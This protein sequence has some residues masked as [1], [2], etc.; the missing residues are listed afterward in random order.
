MEPDNHAALPPGT[1]IG[2][3]RFDGVLGQGGF[4]ITYLGED[5]ALRRAVAIKEYLPAELA[6]RV[7][8]TT[9]KPLTGARVD[10]FGWGLNRFLDEA[11]TLA[12]FHHPN[13]VAVHDVFEQ[14]GTAYMVMQHEAGEGL[15]AALKARRYR[16]EAELRALLAP[17]LEGLEKVHAA[18][19]VHRDIKPANIIIRTDGTPVLIDFG[20]AREAV[21][22][23]TRTLTAMVSE[24]YAPFEQ[25]N[26]T[27]DNN[28]QG[29]WTDIYSLGAMLYRAVT[30]RAPAGALVRA[31]TLLDGNPDPVVPA[32]QAAAGSYS[33][34][35][36]RAIDAA[37]AFRAEDRPQSVAAWRE[38]LAAADDEP[39][40]ATV[41]RRAPPAP[42]RAPAGPT[43]PAHPAGAPPAPSGRRGRVP[44]ALAAAVVVAIAVAAGAWWWSDRDTAPPVAPAG[45][46]AGSSGDRAAVQAAQAEQAA[47][48]EAAGQQAAEKAARLEE[49]RRRRVEAEQAA[50]QEE[51][52]RREI[53]AE[54]ATQEA[55][56]REARIAALLEQAGS[57]IAA[58]R[59][60]PPD[61]DSAASLFAEVLALEPDS[62]EAR[63]G[64]GQVAGRL[65]ADAEASMGARRLDEAAAIIDRADAV[66]PG[67]A[68]VGDARR[69]L[70]AA[71]EALAV[72]QAKAR[73]AASEQQPSQVEA[74]ARESEVERLLAQ[75]EDAIASLRLTSP[76]GDNAVEYLRRVQAME[77]GN[78][79]ASAGLGRV[80]SR[81]V[82][83]ADGA[84]A[85]GDA[86][87]AE[88][89]LER[90][91]SVEAGTEVV[92][93]ARQR[94]AEAGDASRAAAPARS[95]TPAPA[96]APAVT[97]VAEPVPAAPAAARPGLLVGQVLPGRLGS[98]YQ[99][100]EAQLTE[101]LEGLDHA[102][103]GFE[104]RGSY[105]RRGDPA[106][107][108]L[109]ADGLYDAPAVAS[110]VW[111]N[112]TPDV[113]GARQVAASLGADAV[114][115]G[116]WSGNAARRTYE[117][118]FF[119]IDAASGE[120]T[121]R[122]GD[123]VDAERVL[124]ELLAG[125]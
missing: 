66:M 113:A 67:S 51:A 107:R 43:A 37:L 39:H 112:A 17:L 69:R 45:D 1:V 8:G 82:E 92:A 28:R 10:T 47:R 20:S 108:D 80:V 110:L 102:A 86:A 49:E 117:V 33:L 103:A 105:Y 56:E 40:G 36:L 4:G 34:G 70:A 50:R 116:V 121:E 15:D 74:R 31:H 61:A 2:K 18:G 3:Y 97:A 119:L 91:D 65:L 122:V 53:E 44:V 76:A 88:A 114:L 125:R 120:V 104:V 55:A 87:R 123:V 13:I 84:L 22:A 57:A 54:Q 5:T 71:R 93:L 59:L 24:G 115:L 23:E 7:G 98:R 99:P 19:F 25:Y 16:D 26:Q 68:S 106:A 63:V 79:A 73:Q 35:F 29:P 11:R 72:E 95:S 89:F 90:A 83:L 27:R 77:P 81:Y 96:P 109:D 124:A 9:V 30:G 42:H 111:N 6:M 75:A 100:F 101:A 52:R 41:L 48:D 62:I 85:G 118:R 64:L 32:A 58:G 94:I 46:V 21:G 14:N 78:A 12:Q 60:A 38:M